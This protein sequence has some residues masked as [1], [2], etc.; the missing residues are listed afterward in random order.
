FFLHYAPYAVHTP[1]QPIDHLLDKYKNKP[2]SQGQQNAKYATMIQNLDRN[3]GLLISSLKKKG[4]F[5]NTLIIFTSDNGGLYGITQQKPL[6]AGKGSYYEGG[7]REPFFFVWP[8]KIEANTQHNVPIT[9]LDLFPTILAAT[10]IHGAVT[11]FDGEN[12]LPILTGKE[13]AYSRPLFWHFPIYLQA[14]KKQNNENRD[15]L[16]RTRPG[17]VIRLGEW[18]LHYYFEDN[19]VELYNLTTDIEEKNNLA[20]ER[21]NKTNELLQHLKIWWKETNAP[22]PVI[23]NPEYE[24]PL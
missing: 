8:G 15:P 21:P 5:H 24:K 2:P 10:G 7:I 3:I 1:I 14:Y 16:F 9:N 22:I 19:G 20:V 13:Q 23:L 11:N 17:S 18:K 4:V 6:R 12:L